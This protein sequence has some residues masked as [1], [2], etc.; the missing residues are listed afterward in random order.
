MTF[1]RREFLRLAAAAAALPVL[2]HIA[3]AETYPT[4]PVRIVAP[5][6]AGNASDIVAR[7][8]A[9]VLS[10]RL[11]QQ[12]IVDNRPGAGGN[13]G[14]ELVVK[15]PAD[16][17]TLLLVSPS[18]TSNATLYD[19][20]NFN[21][22][23]DIAPVAGIA[24][25]P[26]V[27]VLN[28]SF[29]ANTVPEFIA[30]AKASPGKINMASSGN[31]SLSHMCG[32]LFMTMAG[33]DMVHVPYRASFLPDLLA[34]QVQVVFGPISQTIGYIRAGKLRALAITAATREATLPDIPA[35]AEFVPGYEANGWYGLGAPKA[36]AAAIVDSLNHEITAALADTEIK[37]RLAE[38][39][40]FPMPTTPDQFATFIA[41][42][43]EKWRKLIRAAHIKLD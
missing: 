43:T 21:F 25:A 1:P 32:E 20:L 16:G 18:S 13:I 37:T 26:Y 9:Q 38:L 10:Q 2:P 33:V 27:M 23:S 40:A 22:I 3:K 31:G 41:G 14:T 12:F 36:T 29:P 42:E 39:G 8:A 17:Y 7:L 28:P 6:P 30:Y 34:D 11:G 35:L 5:F 15:A 19:N 4:R 24:R